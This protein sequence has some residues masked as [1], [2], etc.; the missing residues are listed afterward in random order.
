MK[1]YYSPGTCALAVHIALREAGLEADLVKVDLR[2]R[3]LPDGSDFLAVNPLG[4]VPV[5]ELDDGERLTETSALLLYIA[6]RVPTA[7][8]A[9]AVGTFDRSRMQEKLSFVATEL[10]QSFG[11]LFNPS[12]PAAARDMVMARLRGR[13]SWV[14]EHLGSD[15]ANGKEFSVADC[16]LFAVLGFTRPLDIDMSA[17]PALGAYVGRMMCRPAVVAAMR[18]QGLLG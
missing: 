13:L 18:E 5:L 15:F 14:N 3:K 7:G 8:L 2:S 12:L 9:P 6:D 4:Y 11:P 17:W 16:Y 1:L 10:H